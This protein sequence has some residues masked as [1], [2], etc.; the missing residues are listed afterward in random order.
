VH[1]GIYEDNKD[2]LR[3]YTMIGGLDSPQERLE[4]LLRV[5]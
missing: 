1:R 3:V 2:S 5:S 4:E